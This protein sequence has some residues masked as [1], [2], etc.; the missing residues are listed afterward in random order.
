MLKLLCMAY[1]DCVIH[2]LFQPNPWLY[3][4]DPPLY[5]CMPYQRV[6]K[7][8]LF[9]PTPPTDAKFLHTLRQNHAHRISPQSLSG[10]LLQAAEYELQLQMPLTTICRPFNIT[11]CKNVFRIFCHYFFQISH[12][13]FTIIQAY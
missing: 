11:I 7:S 13:S 12:G 2:I 5:I 3:P 1:F 6:L 4:V 8:I 9:E 10:N